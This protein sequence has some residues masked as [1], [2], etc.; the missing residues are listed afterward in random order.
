[1]Y[2]NP[3]IFHLL[4]CIGAPCL[5]P[6][7]EFRVDGS[8]VE[9]L[10]ETESAGASVPSDG[11]GKT[12]PNV[13]GSFNEKY[14]LF[15]APPLLLRLCVLPVAQG[16]HQSPARAEVIGSTGHWSQKVTSQSSKLA[17]TGRLALRELGL[18]ASGLTVSGNKMSLRRLT[19]RRRRPPSGARAWDE[20]C[21]P[22]DPGQRI[23]CP[24]VC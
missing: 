4:L 19:S 23:F 24:S 12:S 6:Q 16:E 3:I 10:A 15:A 8:E 1:M 7:P 18:D 14:P 17:G 22:T 21:L 2:G 11:S 5:K 9:V 20:P 13:R